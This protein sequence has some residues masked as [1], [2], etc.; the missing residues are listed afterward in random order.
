MQAGK[1]NTTMLAFLEHLKCG[2][3]RLRGVVFTAR[4]CV[5]GESEHKV[6]SAVM[7]STYV[8]FYWGGAGGGWGG[9]AKQTCGGPATHN[10]AIYLYFN[11]IGAC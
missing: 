10:T 6:T 5:A 8:R 7:N 1:S 2:M 3:R 11:L 9:A 4:V